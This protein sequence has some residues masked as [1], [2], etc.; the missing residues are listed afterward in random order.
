MLFFALYFHKNILIVVLFKETEIPN[1]KSS[2]I[3]EW[4]DSIFIERPPIVHQN[5]QESGISEFLKMREMIKE[6]LSLL[7]TINVDRY[8]KAIECMEK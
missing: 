1:N 8:L 4:F 3:S 7:V 6:I 5:G 2:V